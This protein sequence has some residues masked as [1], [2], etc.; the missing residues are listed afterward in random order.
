M[1][2]SV[3]EL[4]EKAKHFVIP[5]PPMPENAVALFEDFEH[6]RSYWVDENGQ[7]IKA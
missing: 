6:G 3:E 7:E 4:A 1:P 2:Y 5:N